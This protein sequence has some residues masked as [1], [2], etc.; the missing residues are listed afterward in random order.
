MQEAQEQAKKVEERRSKVVK[1]R[2]AKELVI[3]NKVMKKSSQEKAVYI[4]D[5]V[6]TIALTVPKQHKVSRLVKP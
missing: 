3:T 6:K 4:R 2:R 1:K 5:K